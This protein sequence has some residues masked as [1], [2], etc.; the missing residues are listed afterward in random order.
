MLLL[1]CRAQPVVEH[2]GPVGD[3]CRGVAIFNKGTGEIRDHGS[4][5]RGE[6]MLRNQESCNA[7]VN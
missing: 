7:A 5:E 6:R 4:K 2:F 1:C 3:R